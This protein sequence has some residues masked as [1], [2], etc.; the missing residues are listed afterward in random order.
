M[1]DKV[2]FKRT[3]DHYQAKAGEFRLVEVPA[4]R[5]LMVDGQGDP[6]TAPEYEQAL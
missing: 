4:T 5:Y 3:L 1:P 2:D 6:N